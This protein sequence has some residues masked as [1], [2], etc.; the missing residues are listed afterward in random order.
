MHL[1]IKYIISISLQKVQEKQS[2]KTPLTYKWSPWIPG[3]PNIK[4]EKNNTETKEGRH[5]PSVSIML[6]EMSWATPLS[7]SVLILQIYDATI[8]QRVT[9]SNS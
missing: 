4:Q 6:I 8:D 9:C 7:K 1:P 5:S 2:W 3:M